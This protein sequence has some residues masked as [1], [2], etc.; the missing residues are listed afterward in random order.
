MEP[1]DPTSNA[2]LEIKSEL[3]DMNTRNEQRFEQVDL[4]F[5]RMEWRIDGVEDRLGKRIDGVES[6]L[7]K[8]IDEL[9][10]SFSRRLTETEIR[11]STAI[12]GLAGTLHDVHRLLQDR[13]GRRKLP[14]N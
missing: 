12:N 9:D 6:R 1:N 3:R 8:R 7:D 10:V 5:E 11:L 14:D 13:F 2:L 4:R